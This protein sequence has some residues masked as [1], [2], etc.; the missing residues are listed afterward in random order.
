MDPLPIAAEI[1]RV[2]EN[3]HHGLLELF[4]ERVE[5]S[6]RGLDINEINGD[7][8]DAR[9]YEGFGGVGARLGASPAPLSTVNKEHDGSQ[10]R[11]RGSINVEL[12]DSAG[13]IGQ[14]QRISETRP[15]TVAVRAPAP[16]DLLV[17]GRVEGLVELYVKRGLIISSKDLWPFRA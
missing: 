14:P 16:E 17:I 8:V 6:A 11:A 12:L 5:R 15:R 13:P 9:P 3:P 10:A 1:G 2:L 4:Q 7:E